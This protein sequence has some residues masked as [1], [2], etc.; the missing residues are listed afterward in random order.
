MK[1]ILKERLEGHFEG[2]ARQ[3]QLELGDGLRVEDSEPTDDDTEG[4]DF[5][6]AAG[7]EGGVVGASQMVAV[8]LTDGDGRN[9]EEL[10]NAVKETMN[11]GTKH[12]GQLFATFVVK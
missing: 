3:V 9:L 7:K 6:A 10:H 5:G 1:Q 2:S 8:K 12:L 4:D 11:L